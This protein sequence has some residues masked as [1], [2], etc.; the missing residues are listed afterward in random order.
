MGEEGWRDETEAAAVKR[1]DEC[2][3]EGEE[4]DSKRVEGQPG[5]RT[6]RLGAVP[7]E[8]ARKEETAG[9][10]RGPASWI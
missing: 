6:G 4:Q 7:C 2:L 10:W 5:R 9:T 8:S 1:G 3:E